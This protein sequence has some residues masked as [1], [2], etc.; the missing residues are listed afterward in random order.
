MEVFVYPTPM[1]F[2]SREKRTCGGLNI[3]SM[4]IDTHTN[5]QL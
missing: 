5:E 2:F 4:H 1:A 3:H